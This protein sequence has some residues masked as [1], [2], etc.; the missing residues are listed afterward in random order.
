MLP[1][2]LI[3]ACV[4]HLTLKFDLWHSSKALL[5][6]PRSKM[7]SRTSGF[8]TFYHVYHIISYSLITGA[9]WKVKL[10]VYAVVLGQ[11][12]FIF[13]LRL[14]IFKYIGN[15]RMLFCIAKFSRVGP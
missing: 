10:Y 11:K 7:F 12:N 9:A 13:A 5:V 2:K 4:C 15:C 1:D 14:H 3:H 8:V 6:Q